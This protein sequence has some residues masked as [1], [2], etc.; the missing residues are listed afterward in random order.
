ME[1]YRV[2]ISSIMNP[3]TEDL[4]PERQAARASVER[5]APVAVA[6]A[7]EAEPASPK[8]LLNFYLD[9]V[10]TCDLFMLVIGS[11]ATRPVR[12]EAQIAL[13][14]RKPALVFCKNVVERQP[15]TQELLRMFDVKYDPFTNAVELQ[16][17]IRTALGHH[18]LG[19]IRGESAPQNQ[20]G[21]S[22]GLG[23]D[24]A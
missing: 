8:P 2:F 22:T 14:Y 21:T 16:D 5:F 3:E 24:R 10:R 19:L 9:A 1:A 4:G 13:D 6:W 18:F 17:K 11:H 20:P 15:E 7:F 12:D 23:Y